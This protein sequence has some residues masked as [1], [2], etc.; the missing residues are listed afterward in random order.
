MDH[1]KFLDWLDK[2]PILDRLHSKYK[3]LSYKVDRFFAPKYPI[4]KEHRQVGLTRK[5]RPLKRY[6]SFEAQTVL[7]WITYPILVRFRRNPYAMGHPADLN[8]MEEW[9]EI[10]DKIIYAFQEIIYD[11]W[12]WVDDS[13]DKSAKVQEGLDL[14]ARWYLNLWD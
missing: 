2:H 5:D 12:H 1:D 10:L 3:G 4:T 14:Y 6:D 13:K 11:D 9:H 7:A 8:S